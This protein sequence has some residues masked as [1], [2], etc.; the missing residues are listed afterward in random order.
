MKSTVFANLSEKRKGDVRV[1]SESWNR[2]GNNVGLLEEGLRYLSSDG[3]EPAS[4]LLG[5]DSEIAGLCCTYGKGSRAKLTLSKEDAAMLLRIVEA[6]RKAGVS[7]ELTSKMIS[8]AFSILVDGRLPRE[9]DQVS[10]RLFDI[11]GASDPA[12]KQGSLF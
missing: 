12:L 8:K 9:E 7:E 10:R 3:R 1:F 2:L 11:L 5:A 6:I 4:A